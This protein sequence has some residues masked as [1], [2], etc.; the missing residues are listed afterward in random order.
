MS[1][2]WDGSYETDLS[3]KRLIDTHI[4]D[5]L[6]FIQKHEEQLLGIEESRNT[7]ADDK[8]PHRSI[9]IALDPPGKISVND[10]LHSNDSTE[11]SLRKVLIVLSFLC[12][13]VHELKEI[14]E[15]KFFPSLIIFG[16]SPRGENEGTISLL[17]ISNIMDGSEPSS[18]KP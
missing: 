6:S 7:F 10:I 14:A 2:S 5:T 18:S 1:D 4:Q 15:E 9:R 13:E 3:V 16:R 8:T 12:D 11:H 17:I